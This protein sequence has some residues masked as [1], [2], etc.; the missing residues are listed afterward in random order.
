MNIKLLEQYSNI[1]REIADI[2]QK[3]IKTKRE[4][5]ALEKQI[6]RDCVVGSR[7]DL[8]I[9]VIPVEGIA[10][11]RIDEKRER[12]QRRLERTEYLLSKLEKL[13]EEIET[14]IV[15]IEDSEVR[16]ILTFRYVDDLSWNQVAR[17]MGPG[18]TADAC[19]KKHKRFLTKQ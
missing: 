18:Y 13:R 5:N 12:M 15:D 16:R 3:N 6:A 14:F 10:E 8:T 19:R 4:I 11:Q 7:E 9:G 17:A 1:K 2:E